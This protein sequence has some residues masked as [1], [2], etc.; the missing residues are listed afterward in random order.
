[1][2]TYLGLTLS[3]MVCAL[4]FLK[5]AAAADGTDVAQIDFEPGFLMHSEGQQIDVSRFA[6]GNPVMPGEYPVDLYLNDT[7]MGR[8]T[9]RFAGPNGRATPC[10]EQ[11][12][13]S[14]LNLQSD[15][16]AAAPVQVRQQI[17]QGQCV[18]LDALVTGAGYSFDLAEMRMD[19]SVPQAAL[20][21]TPQG[22]VNPEFWD[23][24]VPSATLAYNLNTYRTTGRL[25]SDTTYAGL[26]AGVNLGSWHFRQ[27]SAIT[28][29]SAGPRQ[30][31]NI[32]T[33]L[34]HD[35]PSWRSQLVLG[36]S[37][38]DG[39]MFDSIGLRGIQL[40][41]DDRMLPDSLRGYA[42][43]IRGIAQSNARVSVTQNGVKLYE[44]T[45]APGPFEINDLYATG[46]GG[47]L[48][49]TVTEADG[50]QHSFSVPYASVVQ[51]LRPGI[52]RYNV[53]VGEAR[54][55]QT[56]GDETL[57]LGTVQHGFTNALT[58]YGGLVASRDYQAALLGTAWNTP[59]GAVAVDVT[60]AHIDKPG[61][62]Q[63][64]GRSLR[65]S[66][67]K[68]V[69]TTQTNLTV[70]AYRYSSSGYW[71]LRQAMLADVVRHAPSE[72]QTYDELHR[73]DRQRNAMQLALNQ[74]LGDRWGNLY[75]VASSQD[76]WNRSGK[77]TEFQVGYN[78]IFRAFGTNVTYNIAGSRQHDSTTGEMTNQVFFSLS[79]PLGDSLHPSTLALA[80]TRNSKDGTS[81]QALLTGSALD[82]SSLTYGVNVNRA[83]NASN[84]GGNVQYRSPVATVSASA[85]SGS[86]Y[87]QYSAGLKGAFVAH[88]GGVTPANDLGDTIGVVEAKDAKGA[89]ITN[90]PGVHVDGRGYAV[91]PY[92][93]PYSLNTVELDPKGL[94]LDVEFKETS[95]Q[96]APR[97]NSVVMV[98]FATVA[99]RAAM[100]NVQMQDNASPPFGTSVLDK[101][102]VE[103]GVVGQSG[104][105]LVRGV[106][107]AGTLTL[108]WGDQP[109]Q[110]CHFSY[111]LPN[112]LAQALTYPQVQATC[113]PPMETTSP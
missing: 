17:A 46:Y 84:G 16:L 106:A 89:R 5:T 71:G 60:Q 113:E 6:T 34:Q 100:I 77:T 91:I 104:R 21:R 23:V 107:E 39:A 35:I 8:R 86:G 98:R 110:Q 75:A 88:S 51:L 62:A 37:Y 47:D 67:S 66:Y 26:D 53:V 41:T 87:S 15:T 69:A 70:A 95:A 63:S 109:D 19:I 24:G 61:L 56:T 49:V 78:N 29:Q 72:R 64:S 80:T 102:G 48:R 36:D 58:G 30:Y 12:L 73:F 40:S 43:L 54:D 4:S 85:S 82:D 25:S 18:A 20:S 38:T 42:P 65:V 7:W 68:F 22:Y 93:T 101:A 103:V 1:M 59:L 2:K 92:L 11:A 32:A 50:S 45:V 96:V 112:K 10:F 83:P 99:G 105:V 90:A 14:Q 13:I 55:G 44:T 94:P 57:F 28:W 79:I 31:Q 108:R 9:V 27:R 33:Y 3:C 81:E 74:A 97:A 76:Y 52:T 111:Q